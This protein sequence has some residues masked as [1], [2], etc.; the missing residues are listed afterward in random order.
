MMILLLL[1]ALIWFYLFFVSLTNAMMLPRPHGSS[2][3]KFG[4]VLIPAR[5][6]EANLKRLLPLL[7]PQVEQV[8]VYDDESTDNT[9]HVAQELGATVIRGGELPDGWTGKNYACYSLAKIAAEVSPSDWWIFLDADTIPQPGFG[10]G[11]RQLTEEYGNRFPV[12][13]GFP[14]VLPGKFPEPIYLF[15]VPW[16][17]L[18]TMPLALSQAT[19]KGYAGF[20][21]G[22]IVLW[23]AS[24]YFEINPHENCKREVLEDIQIG[25][26][27][28]REKVPVLVANLSS[29]LQVAMYRNLP[30]AWNGMS[31]NSFWVTGSRLGAIGVGFLLVGLALGPA[32]GFGTSLA[33][34]MG[35][36]MLGSAVATQVITKMP[37]YTVLTVPISILA[38]AIT[39]FWVAIRGGQ[40]VV[41]KDRTY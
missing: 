4:T 36:M 21:N 29:V 18:T 34:A 28:A 2:G 27:L 39:Q 12:M 10:A 32:F 6:E 23:K 40:S 20:T 8:I 9:A 3:E 22:Q 16:S 14:Q 25:R 19:G 13:T 5:N 30:E 26:Y 35:F 33:G 17:L 41:W 15:W 38:A 31:K 11:I 1:G 24:R 37:I 7:L